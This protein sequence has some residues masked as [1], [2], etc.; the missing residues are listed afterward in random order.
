MEIKQKSTEN[1]KR[2][3]IKN[4]SLIVALIVISILIIMGSASFVA[5]KMYVKGKL[6]EMKIVAPP[7]DTGID[8]NIYKPVR[9]P[10]GKTTD[11]EADKVDKADE[12]VTNILLLSSDSRD[13]KQDTG[14]S[15]SMIVLTIDK[16]NNKLKLTSIMRDLIVEVDSHGRRKLG[17]SHNLGGPLLT[18]KTINQNFKLNIADY[19]QVNFF[20]LANIIDYIGGIEV[21]LT[22]DEVTMEDYAINYYIREISNIENIAPQYVTK[23]GPQILSGIQAVSYARI[24]YVGNS[25]FQRTERQR[26]VL[27]TL[28]KKLSTKNITDI[29]EVVERI[30][31]YVETT[32]KPNDII[33]MASYILVHKMT[34]FE[35]A[36]VPYDGMYTE[37][38]VNGGD[39][40]AWDKEATIDKLHQFIFGTSME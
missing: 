28:Y 17:E 26:T 33:S 21:N 30:A 29:D 7:V 22:A 15:D 18:L 2:K 19:V 34:N 10:D 4:K 5:A 12:S 35:Q 20:G 3:G 38:K 14:N 36:R 27:S 25:D 24:R 1:G 31:P 16:K 40:L 8:P 32:I 13:P 37:Q 23:P 6:S 11:K 39:G 9:K